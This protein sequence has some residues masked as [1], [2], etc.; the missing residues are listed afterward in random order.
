MADVTL[1]TLFP[2]HTMPCNGFFAA[3]ALPDGGSG[4]RC[5][6]GAA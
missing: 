1:T 4:A 6:R 2:L 5:R 3:G